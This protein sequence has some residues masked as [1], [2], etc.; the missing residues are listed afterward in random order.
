MIQL[1]YIIVATI[2]IALIAFVGVFALAMK[3]HLLSKILPMLV[4][5]SAGTLMGSAFIHLLPEA[6]KIA[7]KMLGGFCGSHGICGAAVRHWHFYQPDCRCNA[8]F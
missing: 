3:E 7:E 1:M 6:V 5:L 8:T 2:A 4:S